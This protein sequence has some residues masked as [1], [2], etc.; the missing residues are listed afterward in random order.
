MMSHWDHG[1]S[2]RDEVEQPLVAA[3]NARIGIVL[4]VVYL[5]FYAGFVLLG[6]F[7]LSFLA[8]RPWAGVN[9]AIWYG[10]GLIVSAMAVALLYSWLC[11]V[12]DAS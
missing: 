10:F 4:F 8:Q 1:A 6:T 2:E 11:R 5:A 12:R 3:R 7:A 9:L